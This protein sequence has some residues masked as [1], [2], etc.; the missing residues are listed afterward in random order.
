M[1]V[2]TSDGGTG[3]R[4]M[5]VDDWAMYSQIGV[6]HK[7]P[8]QKARPVERHNAFIRSASQRAESQATKESS[9]ISF[10]IA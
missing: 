4:D 1:E 7:A 10:T 9:C 8:H 5:A 3:M 2:L 6:K